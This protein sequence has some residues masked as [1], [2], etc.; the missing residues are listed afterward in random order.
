M[1]GEFCV[2]RRVTGW[3]AAVSARLPPSLAMLISWNSLNFPA[4]LL[5]NWYTYC[6]KALLY[7]NNDTFCKQWSVLCLNA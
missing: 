1:D 6:N 7:N 2:G 5:L 3:P 4:Y